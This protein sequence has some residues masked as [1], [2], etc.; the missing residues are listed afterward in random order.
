MITASPFFTA[1]RSGF[2]ARVVSLPL[3]RNEF[4]ASV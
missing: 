3:S 2:P 1:I 4:W